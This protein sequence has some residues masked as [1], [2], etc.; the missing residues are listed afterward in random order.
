ETLKAAAASFLALVDEAWA[1]EDVD[2]AEKSAAAG[3]ANARKAKDVATAARAEAK[4]KELADQKQK[5]LKFKA[6]RE[7]LKANPED[8][9]A[10]A[11][12]GQNFCF[13]LGNWEAGLPM[14]AKG[15]QE[16]LKALA[17]RDLA[18]PEQAPDQIALAD[19]WRELAEKETG[20]VRQRIRERAAFWYSKAYGAS[21]GL[22][23]VKIEKR[24]AEIAS[25]AHKI[26]P[27]VRDSISSE[28]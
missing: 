13:G 11:E 9:A 7:A 28:G 6:A 10:N 24:L 20:A 14:L 22:A 27:V 23:K 1:R 12:V 17:T 25:P 21:T 8:P 2:T 5:L 19:E 4:G 18:N 3:A 15:S 16:A 26:T